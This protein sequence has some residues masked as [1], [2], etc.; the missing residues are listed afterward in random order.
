MGVS[1]RGMGRTGAVE[2]DGDERIAWRRAWTTGACVSQSNDG[3][4]P[5]LTP[6]TPA[7]NFDV[8]GNHRSRSIDLNSSI[9]PNQSLLDNGPMRS[10]TSTQ[11]KG[12]RF[13]LR[14]TKL[15]TRSVIA[16][17]CD[18]TFIHTKESHP[19]TTNH[20]SLGTHDWTCLLPVAIQT[21]HAAIFV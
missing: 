17:R 6:N 10:T 2:E 4:D 7:V 8:L 1:S 19:L 20:A 9:D 14:V 21:A 3:Q 18:G 15:S 12:I 13:H 16:R 5:A 11:S